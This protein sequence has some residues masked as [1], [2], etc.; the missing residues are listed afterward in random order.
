M[1]M[2]DTL[3]DMFTRIRNAQMA[4]KSKVDIPSSRTKEAIAKVL[5]EEGYIEGFAVDGEKKPTL[6][7]EL[8]YFE[9]QPVIEKIARVSRPGLRV[10]KSAGEIPKVKGGLG[11]MVVSTNQGIISDRA[12]RQAN[13]GGE[14]ICEVS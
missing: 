13:V 11:V 8:R 6:T 14:L 2:Q 9:G 7:V 5:K 10:Y 4:R 3:A 1:S 12:A